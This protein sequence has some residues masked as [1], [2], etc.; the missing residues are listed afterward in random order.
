MNPRYSLFLLSFAFLFISACEGCGLDPAAS[1]AGLAHVGGQDAGA[2][3]QGDGGAGLDS[4]QPD[5]S[6]VFDAGEHVDGGTEELDSGTQMNDAGESGFS[7]EDLLGDGGLP[8]ELACLPGGLPEFSVAGFFDLLA[9]QSYTGFSE[10]G[11]V[12][13]DQTCAPGLPC[14]ELCGYAACAEPGHDGGEPEC[15]F[16]TRAI[17][18]DGAEDCPGTADADTC[19]YSLQGTD[20]RAEAECVFSLDFDGGL[21]FSMN[22]GGWTI[23]ITLGLDGGLEPDGGL[24]VDAGTVIDGGVTMPFDGGM[25]AGDSDH[26][27]SGLSA[28]AGGSGDAG[29]ASD[30]GELVGDGGTLIGAGDGG[31]ADGGVMDGGEE[32]DWSFLEEVFDQGVPVCRNTLFDCNLFQGEMCCTSERLVVLDLGLCM[33]ALMCLGGQIP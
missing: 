21:P 10:N 31:S 33:P 15:P 30:A 17:H 9:F 32:I 24:E 3:E 1:D 12:C 28:D 18:C 6:V 27:D 13:G 29:L 2:T 8:P 16:F 26:V 11:V 4:G 22:D 7:W 23:P 5:A 20:C 19:C 14:C 25:D